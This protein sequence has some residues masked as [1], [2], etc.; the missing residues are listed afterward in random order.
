MVMPVILKVTE[1]GQEPHVIKLPVDVWQ[2]GGTWTFK[3][4]STGKLTA[5]EL[6][7]DHVLPDADRS[8]DVWKA[9]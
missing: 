9:Q 4:P 1:A 3:Y 7:P 8:N 2:R 6:D 5:I